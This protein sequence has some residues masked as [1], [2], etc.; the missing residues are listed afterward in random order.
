M[1]RREQTNDTDSIK[2]GREREIRLIKFL[3]NPFVAD[4]L[5][6][7]CAAGDLF[8]RSSCTASTHYQNIN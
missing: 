2:I 3:S 1:G 8:R 4:F 7:D 6:S 5:P